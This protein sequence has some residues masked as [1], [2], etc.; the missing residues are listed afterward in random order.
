[1]ASQARQSATYA[2]DGGL[3]AYNS[4]GMGHSAAGTVG[5]YNSGG[6]YQAMGQTARSGPIG[7]QTRPGSAPVYGARARPSSQLEAKV[8]RRFAVDRV[9][10]KLYDTLEYVA[11]ERGCCAEV[12]VW[13]SQHES[14]Q[15]TDVVC[16]RVRMCVLRCRHDAQ[17]AEY[18]KR[19]QAIEAVK[20]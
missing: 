1:M 14:E 6:G 13:V 8:A 18:R 12:A 11:G 2:G 17:A 15:V 7:Y 5:F 4:G 16:N 19:K 9:V 3:M 20:V 10:D